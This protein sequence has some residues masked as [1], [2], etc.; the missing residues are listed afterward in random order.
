MQAKLADLKAELTELDKQIFCINEE[1][2]NTE[3][4]YVS[5]ESTFQQSE[6]V[7]EEELPELPAAEPLGMRLYKQSLHNSHSIQQQEEDISDDLLE[8]REPIE[9]E[10]YVPPSERIYESIRRRKQKTDL[11][12]EEEERRFRAAYSFKPVLE[13]TVPPDFIYTP[14]HLFRPRRLVNH[15]TPCDPSPAKH[16]VPLEDGIFARQQRHRPKAPSSEC[17]A[18]T[19]KITEAEKQELIERLMNVHHIFARHEDNEKPLQ[20]AKIM[21]RETVDRL[22]G[23]S[24][25]KKRETPVPVPKSHI[26]SVSKKLMRNVNEDLYINGLE[27]RARNEAKAKEALEWRRKVE[28]HE[29]E[30]H[31]KQLKFRKV[32]VPKTCEVA[33]MAE[34]IE[35]MEQSRKNVEKIEER[36][37]N[38]VVKPFSCYE[39]NY[40][41]KK[42]DENF[43][44]N[45][46]LA[47]ID[48][49]LGIN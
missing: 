45:E 40:A 42:E 31:R 16:V 37:V 24:L 28:E 44:A 17:E 35:R 49:L 7:E 41:K 15:D 43:A 2:N 25:A 23:E 18:S 1:L 30:E 39:R 33:G 20:E 11:L 3:S 47:E 13:S 26:N 29:Y 48:A 9:I 6:D 12:R 8:Q 22:V 19:K 21:R 38:V 34:Y 5:F 27:T 36:P 14:G 32:K 10:G 4:S 46:V